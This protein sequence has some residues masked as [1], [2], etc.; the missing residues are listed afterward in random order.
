MET[1]TLPIPQFEWHFGQAKTRTGRISKKRVLVNSMISETQ[2]CVKF[3]VTGCGVEMDVWVPMNN[4][5]AERSSTSCCYRE[6]GTKVMGIWKHGQYGNTRHEE[7]LLVDWK[8][9]H[10]IY[11]ADY[12]DGNIRD[13]KKFL[14]GIPS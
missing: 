2:E 10:I 14:V 13:S 7:P 9:G 11:M 4:M 3:H 1:K 5:K 6:D 12:H 8:T